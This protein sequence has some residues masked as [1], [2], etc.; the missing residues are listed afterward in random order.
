MALF[1][2]KRDSS[3][4]KKVNTELLDRVVSQ[5][6]DYYQYYLPDTKA[7]DTQNLYGEASAQKSYYSPVRITCLLERGDQSYV[8]DDQFGVDVTQTMTFKFFKPRLIEAGLVP[9]AGDIVEVRGLYYELD[10]I[11]EN[12]FFL[13]KDADYP[14]SVGPDFGE[15][16]SIICIGHYTRVTRLQIQ[17]AR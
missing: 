13:G 2:S 6:V 8:G 4:I 15:S 16:L 7:V 3:F 14:K 17:R 10:Q 1:G 5:E 11:N 12:Q 9:T